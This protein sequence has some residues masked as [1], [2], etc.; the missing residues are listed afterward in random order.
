MTP[1]GTFLSDDEFFEF[2]Q[3]YPLSRVERSAAGEIRVAPLAG[4]ETAFRRSELSAQLGTWAR[5]D[6]RG[7]PFASGT[8]FILASGAAMSP[9]ASWVDNVRLALLTRE[10]KRRFPRLCPDFVAELTSPTDRLKVVQKKMQ[11]WID[12]GVLLGW[13]LDADHR[14]AYIYRPGRGSER[15]DEPQ[16]LVGEGPVAGF[17]LELDS[18]WASL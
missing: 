18:I 15:L 8:E 3:S 4:L 2:C 16:R 17:V 13:L 14:T 12:N 11:E 10:Q 7:K 9:S 1:H 5:A 6:A